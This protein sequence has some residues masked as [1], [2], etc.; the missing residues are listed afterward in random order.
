MKYIFFVTAS[1]EIQQKQIKHFFYVNYCKYLQRVGSLP[2]SLGL[3]SL[4]K[5]KRLT[6]SFKCCTIFREYTLLCFMIWMQ[7]MTYLCRSYKESI[8]DKTVPL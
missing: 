3:N 5:R 8:D 6:I 7:I 4:I 2:Q 1:R